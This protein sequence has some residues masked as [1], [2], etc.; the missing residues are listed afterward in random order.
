[1]LYFLLGCTKKKKGSKNSYSR[2]E[3]G[4]GLIIGW[5]LFLNFRKM[6]KLNLL[7][8]PSFIHITDRQLKSVTMIAFIPF[9]RDYLDLSQK[10]K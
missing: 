8:T 3:T 1:M 6:T 4:E 7:S 5:L 9:L 2:R 10:W